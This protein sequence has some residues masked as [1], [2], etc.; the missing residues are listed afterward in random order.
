MKGTIRPE[1]IGFAVK[2]EEALQARDCKDGWQNMTAN[3]V[4]GKIKQE[5]AEL[6][7]E[8]MVNYRSG[9]NNDEEFEHKTI[10]LVASCMM[11]VD[12][13]SRRS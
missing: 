5:F 1:V 12:N 3:Q 10:D 7:I 4:M 13:L 6:K 8:A 9:S 11:L 2:M